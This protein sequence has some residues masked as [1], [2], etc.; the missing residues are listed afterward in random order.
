MKMMLSALALVVASAAMT[1]CATVTREEFDA[2]KAMAEQAQAEAAEAKLTAADASATANA[3]A[4]KAAAA[5][6]VAN[7]ANE[8]S[9]DTESKIDRMFKKAMYK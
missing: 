4:D 6:Q 1:G 2:V 9:K 3:A 8:R 7:E 5:Q